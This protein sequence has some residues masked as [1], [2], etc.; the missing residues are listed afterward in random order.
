MS[1]F[2]REHPSEFEAIGGNIEAERS[3]IQA[4]TDRVWNTRQVE[5][6]MFKWAEDDKL[7]IANL[8]HGVPTHD[9]HDTPMDGTKCI[10][11]EA[12]VFWLEN[13]QQT[14]ATRFAGTV[15]DF[16]AWIATLPKRPMLS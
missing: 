3:F 4:A 12:E 13:Q 8:D 16:T 15:Q 2:W 11:C 14:A 1:A 7:T 5:Y 6:I 10:D 9:K